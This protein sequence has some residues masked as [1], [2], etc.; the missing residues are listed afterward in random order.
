MYSELEAEECGGPG[1]ASKD[2]VKGYKRSQSHTP[3]L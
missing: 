1:R 3:S 2:V